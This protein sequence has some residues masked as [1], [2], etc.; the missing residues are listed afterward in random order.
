MYALQQHL[1][2]HACKTLLKVHINKH[3]KCYII[4]II[5]PIDSLITYSLSESNLGQIVT[6]SLLWVCAR[7]WKVSNEGYQETKV[8]FSGTKLLH[9]LSDCILSW[10]LQIQWIAV[11]LQ[12]WV[13]VLKPQLAN[14]PLKNVLI[15]I[16]P[17]CLS[18]M[19]FYS[20]DFG[21][22]NSL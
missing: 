10:L 1:T 15:T 5:I 12:H 8:R 9:L 19:W 21:Y 13:R 14:C 2:S 3:A 4:I 18:Q 20:S 7:N 22:C 11:L 16:N 6:V 17:L